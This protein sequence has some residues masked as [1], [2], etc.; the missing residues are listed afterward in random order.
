[1]MNRFT[2]GRDRL[3]LLFLLH[4]PPVVLDELDELIARRVVVDAPLHHLLSDVEVNLAGGAAHVAKVGI[5]HL[6]RAVHDAAHD[7]DGHAGEV[8]GARGNSRGHLLQVEQSAAAGRAR[9]V[10]SLRVA[11][12]RTLEEAERGAADVIELRGGVLDEHAV[13][14][15]VAEQAANL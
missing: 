4:P 11:H 14:E 2:L 6:A 12:A 3:L 15:A 13:A 5:R 8:P 10:L 7:R 9:H 1:M